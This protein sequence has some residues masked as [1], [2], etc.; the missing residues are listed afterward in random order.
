MNG[1]TR[2]TTL[3]LG[4]ALA[5][6]S[7]AAED[8]QETTRQYVA[9][10]LHYLVL[11]EDRDLSRNGLGAGLIY[12]REI[13][14]H[15]WWETE[16][17]GYGLD[18]GVEGSADFYQYIISTGVAYAFG[19]RKG[20]TP[21][22][23]AQIGG[24]YEDVVPDD[25][26]GLNLHANVGV[27]AVTGPL[28]DNG[29]KMRFDAR[30]MYDDFDGITGTPS[31][32]EGGF[33]DWRFSLGLEVPLGVT[34]TVEVE[35]IVYETREVEKVVEV[36]AADTD[37]DGIPDNRDKCPN[38]LAG[39]KV[40]GDGCLIKNQTISFNNI[41]FELNSS[42]ITA[43]SRPTLDRLAASLNAQ[44]DFNVEVAGHTD[45]SG[46]AEYNENLSDQRA[47][48]VRQYLVDQGVAAERLTARGYGEVDPV[49][50]NET[51]SGRAM[52]RR[53]EFRVSEQ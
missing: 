50:S 19:D 30:Y 32:D 26:D 43:T 48:A 16:G 27:G 24:V 6:Q 40:D 17:A 15:W 1:S 34:K 31:E 22:V 2:L 28:F 11:D 47:H 20:F 49:A 25:D 37:G 52:N 10:M 12:G 53:V 42:K 21:F 51:A 4:V 18:S 9:P 23:L 29:L 7:L 13:S 44:T 14:E 5:T 41:G 33:N 36:A 3:A 39:G 35:K 45:S 46:S 8:S 38:T